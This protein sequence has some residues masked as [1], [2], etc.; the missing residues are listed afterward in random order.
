MSWTFNADDYMLCLNC[1]EATASPVGTDFCSTKCQ[2]EYNSPEKRLE[3][4]IPKRIEYAQNAIKKAEQ[5]L[6]ILEFFKNHKPIYTPPSDSI[7]FT[8]VVRNFKYSKKIDDK[9]Y[10]DFDFFLGR[11]QK[12]KIFCFGRVNYGEYYS[13]SEFTQFLLDLEQVMHEGKVYPLYNPQQEVFPSYFIKDNFGNIVNWED[14]LYLAIQSL[15]YET[16]QKGLEEP[17]TVMFGKM[18][19]YSLAG[20][21]NP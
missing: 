2:E 14:F 16:P 17:K 13:R 4:A 19:H 20:G 15:V 11:W 5:E 1:G 9:E 6:R 12:N 7:V 3:R 10:S 21:L 8:W 18:H